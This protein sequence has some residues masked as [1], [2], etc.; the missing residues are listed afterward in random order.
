MLDYIT[1]GLEKCVDMTMKVPAS[2]SPHALSYCSSV[3][4]YYF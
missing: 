2:A 4:N 1:D 3:K